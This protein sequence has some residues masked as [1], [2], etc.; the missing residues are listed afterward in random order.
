MTEND[1]KEI[2][3]AISEIDNISND[4]TVILV[5]ASKE[6]AENVETFGRYSIMAEYFSDSELES[7]VSGFK[8]IASY[9]DISYSEKEFISKIGTNHFSTLPG[10]YKILYSSTGS[11]IHKCKSGIIP[12][13]CNFFH[14]PYCSNDAYTS[15]LLENK[16][17]TFNLLKFY[18][19]PIAPYWVFDQINGWHNSMM[20]PKDTVLIAKPAYQCSSIGIGEEAVSEISS[21]YLEYIKQTSELFKQPIIVQ[22]FIPGYE[23][24]IP[25]FDLDRI[26]APRSMGIAIDNIKNLENRF[27]SYDK[28]SE[29]S[30]SYFNFDETNVA[31]SNNLKEISLESYQLL[32]LSGLV[33]VDFRINNGE[34][35]ITDYNNTPHLSENHSYGQLFLSLGFVYNDMLKCLLYTGLKKLK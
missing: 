20:P 24:E 14:L 22:Q 26:I 21:V 17:H 9:I 4:L 12:G 8:G 29:G 33:R 35:F 27:L 23:V 5:V 31:T 2:V 1:Q 30:Y 11:G 32:E 19:L 28:L 34:F 6:H 16:V 18:G 10:K 25:M 7:L 3:H 13:I 15:S